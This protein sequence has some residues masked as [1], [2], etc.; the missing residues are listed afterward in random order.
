MRFFTLFVLITQGAWLA[1]AGTVIKSQHETSM[2]SQADQ[3]VITADAREGN[4]STSRNSDIS[5]A[6]RDMLDALEVMQDSYFD[7]FSGTWLGA[8]DWTS[9]VMGTHVS[10]TLSSIV[11]SLDTASTAACSE[12]LSWQNLID[13]YYAQTSAFYFGENAFAL[14]NQAYDD[15]LWVVLGW[16]ENLKFAE[17]YSLKHWDY[18]QSGGQTASSDGW[19]GLQFV[20]MAAHRA[21]VFYDL[22]SAGW[23]ESLCGGGM[24]WN[25]YLTPY[26]NAIT[27]ELFA[28]ASIGMYLYFPGDNNTSPYMTS[29]PQGSMKPHDP[30]YLENAIKS[31]KWIMESKMRN[32]EGLYEDGFHVTGWRRYPNGT[33]N[34]GTGNCDD[35]NSMV[36]TY[37]QG[38]ILS[39]SRG[40]WLATGARSYLEDGHAQIESVVRATGWPNTDWR[41]AG[42]GRGGV[43][44]EFCDHRGY[45][46]QDGQT[47]KGIFF[48][49]LSDFC[50]PL[51]PQE[52]AF[53]AS[54]SQTAD[55]DRDV[56]DYHLARCAAYDKWVVHNSEAALA[57]RNSDGHF[58]MWWMFRGPRHNTM[59]QIQKSTNLPVG[60]DDHLNPEPQN[61][62]DHEAEPYDWND[63]GRGRTVETQSGGLA[64]LRARWN[65]QV[66]SRRTST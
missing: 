32:P 5:S 12:M 11:S 7:M 38:V 59:A 46:S 64:V 21:R 65:W 19:H 35:L 37:N 61:W 49:H 66:Y 55:F 25:P 50:R 44:E 15:M 31:Y 30:T 26:K 60:A 56:Y 22:A 29:S 18:V 51:W 40:L 20:P 16:L 27:N 62:S 63:R 41:W 1:R 3:L 14:R 10:A 54:T 6:L 57:T 36:Y 2:G 42:L 8:I 45:C 17:M 47:F 9:A 43:M 23:D 52:E 48:H 58:G 33:I 24:T 39:A 28:A 34:P 4:G 53:L 13:R